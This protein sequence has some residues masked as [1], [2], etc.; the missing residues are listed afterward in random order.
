M[1]CRSCEVHQRMSKWWL[2]LQW[3]ERTHAQL[4]EWTNESRIQRTSE[5]VNQW[6][7]QKWSERLMCFYIFEV[8]IELSLLCVFCRKLLRSRRESAETE[9]LLRRPQEPHYPK[10]RMV[11]RPRVFLPVSSH[12]SKVLQ[13]TL[14]KK[15][16]IYIQI[17]LN[18]IVVNNDKSN[19]YCF[20]S[21]RYM[22]GL[23][24]NGVC[25][26]NGLF[27]QG[28]LWKK[29]DFGVCFQTNPYNL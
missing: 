27:L 23:L 3:N 14:R 4:P 22:I 24:E 10:K 29:Q 18:W 19:V 11:S 8:Q 15:W 21:W 2:I 12:A 17:P 5:P 20:W 13:A 26:P 25:P 7:F 1:K 16:Q 6:I 9:T 28:K